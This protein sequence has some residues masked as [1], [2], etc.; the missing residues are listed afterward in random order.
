M[1][2]LAS[3]WTLPLIRR[4]LCP[5]VWLFIPLEQA[6]SR[7]GSSI[8]QGDNPPAAGSIYCGHR[9]PRPPRTTSEIAITTQ[10]MPGWNS[11]FSSSHSP[12]LFDI[13]LSELQ[14]SMV[15]NANSPDVPLLTGV[16]GVEPVAMPGTTVVT[17]W[18]A[19]EP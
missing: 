7:S 12:F 18:R 13:I 8:E 2:S 10:R 15:I 4:Q 5:H 3:C 14:E 1:S 17:D 16:R 6:P 9:L 11:V 19:G